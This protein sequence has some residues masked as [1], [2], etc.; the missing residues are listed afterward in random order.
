[1]AR[2][3]GGELPTKRMSPAVSSLMLMYSMIGERNEG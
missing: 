1:M 3:T 2:I